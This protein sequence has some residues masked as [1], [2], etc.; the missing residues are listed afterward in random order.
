MYHFLQSET[1]EQLDIDASVIEDSL[2][3]VKENTSCIVSSYKG[4]VFSVEPPN[5]VDLVVTQADPSVAGN[6]AT[7]VTKLVKVE[8]DAWVRVPDFINEGE[9]IKIDTRTGEYLS[10]S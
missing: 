10:R 4:A 8:T 6:T 9:K 1:F 7:N 3:F 5:S 2:K